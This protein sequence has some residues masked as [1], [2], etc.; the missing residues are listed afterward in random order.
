[1][2]KSQEQLSE[3]VDE[4]EITDS[5]DNSSQE[6]SEWHDSFI[7]T[8]MEPG[9]NGELI[10]SDYPRNPFLVVPED[11]IKK[12]EES[13]SSSTHS[14]NELDSSIIRDSP[15]NPFLSPPVAMKEGSGNK[16]NENQFAQVL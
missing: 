14:V 3:Q 2:W 13:Y 10:E 11:S 5:D 6:D 12:D 8:I 9:S 1:L 7:E 15:N 4:L 16:I